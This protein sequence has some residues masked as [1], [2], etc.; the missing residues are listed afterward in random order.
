MIIRYKK[1]DWWHKGYWTASSGGIFSIASC[2]SFLG[3]IGQLQYK[4]PLLLK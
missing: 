2:Y 3:L 4:T 1:L